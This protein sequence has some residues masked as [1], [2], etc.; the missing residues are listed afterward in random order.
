M[1]LAAVLN[2][3]T[4][5]AIEKTLPEQVESP[6]AASQSVPHPALPAANENHVSAPS[7]HGRQM[8]ARWL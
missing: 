5:P 6:K 3:H 8:R 1:F 7:F 4:Q 2:A